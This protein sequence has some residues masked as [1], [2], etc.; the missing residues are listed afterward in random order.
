MTVI[1]DRLRET[2][3]ALTA[4]TEYSDRPPLAATVSGIDASPQPRRRVSAWVMAACIVLLVAGLAVGVLVATNFTDGS[5]SRSIVADG[6]TN[7]VIVDVPLPDGVP[8]DWK[9]LEYEGLRISFPPT[10]TV[11][12]SGACPGADATLLVGPAGRNCP[13]PTKG[14]WVWIAP[15]S[16]VTRAE[17]ERCLFNRVG[18]L[19][20][21]LVLPTDAQGDVERDLIENRDL[22]I[23]AGSGARTAAEPVM[24]TLRST[25][26]NGV[27]PQQPSPADAARSFVDAYACG[28]CS[29]IRALVVGSYHARCPSPDA[30]AAGEVGSAKTEG[31]E[32]WSPGDGYVRVTLDDQRAYEVQLHYEWSDTDRRGEWK[33]VQVK[34]VDPSTPF[35]TVPFGQPECIPVGSATGTSPGCVHRDDYIGVNVGDGP[36]DPK[37]M[38]LVDR[39]GGIPVYKNATS[40]KAIGVIPASPDIKYLPYV[41][42]RLIPRMREIDTCMATQMAHQ[43]DPTNPDISPQCRTLLRELGIKDS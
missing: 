26:S 33:V 6:G 18:E 2:Y 30:T 34:R 10:W 7:G 12:E 35:S 8:A 11:L 40:Q 37:L 31:G 21:C 36:Q 24:S 15:A 14:R 28:A 1:E 16:V 39:Y 22:A 13:R 3:G 42:N 23:L 25:D 41:P 9:T 32:G 38:D 29:E 19:A 5:H 4:R 17:R 27:T 20:L 43:F